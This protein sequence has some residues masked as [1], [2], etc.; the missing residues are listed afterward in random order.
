MK[1]TKPG[2]IILLA[3]LLA[4]SF[5]TARAFMHFG[6]LKGDGHVIKQ[7]REIKPFTSLVLDGVFDA[8]IVQGDKEEVSVETDENL[9]EVIVVENQGDKLVL[10]MKDKIN[11]EKATKS[12]VYITLKNIDDLTVKGVGNVKSFNTLKLNS[13]KLTVKGV[14]D[15]NL[16][17][18]CN[19]LDA[20]V[21]SVG[22]TSLA[23]NTGETQIVNSGVGSLHAFDL[24]ARQLNLRNSGVGSA[25]VNATDE[26]QIESLG[27]GNV[28]Y[29]GDAKVT[30]MNSK[31]IGSVKKI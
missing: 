9:Q 26:I 22:N 4:G 29:K 28:Y 12:V 11:M 27:I 16:G 6:R 1:I 19:N 13:L 5:L 2:L 15:V 14:G 8:E 20:K 23:G 18:A 24:V 30:R 17:L 25:E 10:K 31:G 7:E 21:S 3:V